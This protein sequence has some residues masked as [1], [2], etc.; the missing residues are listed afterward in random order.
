MSRAS[1]SM[2]RISYVFFNRTLMINWNS[3]P[4]GGGNTRRQG[5]IPE[6]LRNQEVQAALSA[7][8]LFGPQNQPEPRPASDPKRRRVDAG[9]CKFSQTVSPSRYAK[10]L[11][12]KNSPV[13]RN[14]PASGSRNRL[15][16]RLRQ[17]GSIAPASRNLLRKLLT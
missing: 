13:K 8:D 9:A 14:E 6:R 3:P 2:R 12:L 7:K 4:P 15:L 5:A 16:F 17:L 1:Q 10:L 11:D